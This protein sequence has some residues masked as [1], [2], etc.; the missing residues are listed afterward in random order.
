M[1]ETSLEAPANPREDD[2]YNTVFERLSQDGPVAGGIA[3]WLYKNAKREWVAECKDKQGFRPSSGEM[4]NYAATQTDVV[5]DAYRAHAESIL[6]A[7][8]ET[9]VNKVRPS[10]LSEVLKGN[11]LRSFWPSF[12]AS[13]AFTT[14]LLLL[15][16]AVAILGPGLPIQISVPPKP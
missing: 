7:Y 3:Y 13:V 2:A 14:L 10:I 1:V 5:L 11:F 16:M 6:A 8:A 12:W 9:V 15:A 4:K